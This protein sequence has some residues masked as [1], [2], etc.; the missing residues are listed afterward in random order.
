MLNHSQSEYFI[1]F[2]LLNVLR[3]VITT[4][5]KFV[6]LELGAIEPLVNLVDDEDSE[7]RVNSLMVWWLIVFLYTILYTI[8]IM[9]V[10]SNF[11]FICCHNS[12]I[13]ACIIV[14]QLKKTKS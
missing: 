7:V 13:F 5:G 2:Y 11:S 6:A 3:I 1:L 9:Y 4:K 12:L 10:L 8:T 14:Y